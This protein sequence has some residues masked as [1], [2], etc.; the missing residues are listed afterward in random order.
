MNGE[1][2][3]KSSVDQEF[4]VDSLILI[5][6]VFSVILH[7]QPEN[8]DVTGNNLN[9]RRNLFSAASGTDM[10]TATDATIQTDVN[11]HHVPCSRLRH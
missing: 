7:V 4:Y 8:P 6:A 5:L 10:A 2:K 1:L 9:A 3:A 11:R